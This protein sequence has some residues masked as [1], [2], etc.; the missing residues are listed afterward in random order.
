MA[1]IR[2]S[3]YLQGYHTPNQNKENINIKNK[4]ININMALNLIYLIKSWRME[5]FDSKLRPGYQFFIPVT[6]FVLLLSSIAKTFWL[7]QNF[8]PKQNFGLTPT[9]GKDF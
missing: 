4:G 2:L 6:L 5:V 1:L 3:F 9:Y 7:K 8:R